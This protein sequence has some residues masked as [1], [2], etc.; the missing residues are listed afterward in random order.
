MCGALEPL[1][2]QFPFLILSFIQFYLWLNKNCFSGAP[3]N[4]N[5]NENPRTLFLANKDLLPS[6]KAFTRYSSFWLSFF[7]CRPQQI[8]YFLTQAAGING[9]RLISLWHQTQMTQGKQGI[10]LGIL[11]LLYL[12][13]NSPPRYSTRTG[14]VTGTSN[15]GSHRTYRS[16]K[17]WNH[18]PTCKQKKGLP[19]LL[20]RWRY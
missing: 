7:P 2:T 14:T 17:N 18:T 12:T 9:M 20:A 8:L 3:K 13:V 10:P 1:P 5:C 16:N 15:S 19:R 4:R 6:F 11:N